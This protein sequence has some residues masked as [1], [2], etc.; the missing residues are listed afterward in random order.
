MISATYAYISN[1]N[2]KDITVLR[3]DPTSGA[4]TPVETARVAT[5]G[6]D[7]GTMPLAVS[8]DRRFL[9]AALRFEPFT[10]VAF[11]I[12]AK[13]GTLRPLGTAPLPDSMAS[14]AT[15]RSGKF[16]LGSSYGGNRIAVS[17]IDANGQVRPEATV[18]PT[19]K[20][21][22]AI[23]ADPENRFLFATNLGSDAV[24][25]GRFDAASGAVSDLALTAAT[26]KAGAGPRHFAFHP[27][28]RFF[29]LVNELDASLNVYAYDGGTGA[30]MEIQSTT[31]L[32]PGFSGKPWAADIHP[33]PDGRFL[34]ASERASSTL[35]GFK[36]DGSGKLTS[37]GSAET[38][39]QPRGFAIDPSGRW[40]LSVGQLTNGLSV[41]AIDGTTGALTRVKQLPVGR[42]P[43]WVEIV[44]LP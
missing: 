26:T 19:G 1:A 36:V 13:T 22:H 18:I 3:L 40:L 38:E 31:I 42:N 24:V 2:S 28:G 29:Y 20:S 25:R 34:Y 27:N 41:H 14:I 4:L 17:R 11:A 33:T 32:P 15:D 7:G 6:P 23:G 44:A 35:A 9:Y 30:L 21:A 16:L 10:A 12:E 8:P 43:Q 39:K 5:G 37:I